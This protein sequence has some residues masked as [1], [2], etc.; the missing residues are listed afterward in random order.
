[1]QVLLQELACVIA[2]ALLLATHTLD[3]C[4]S[5]SFPWLLG[6]LGAANELD[7]VEALQISGIRI[8][9]TIVIAEL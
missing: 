7:A 9:Y 1:M 4:G 2:K 6:C 8:H 5:P 3:D